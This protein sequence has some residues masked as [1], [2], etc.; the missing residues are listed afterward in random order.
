MVLASTALYFASTCSD[1]VCLA[2][3]EHF[4]M[5]NWQAA[6]LCEFST[7]SNPFQFLTLF[8]SSFYCYI[9][10]MRSLFVPPVQYHERIH[11]FLSPKTYKRNFE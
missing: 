7:N 1:H 4:R 6:V 8:I 9:N 5:Y 3:R 11:L 10:G 2:S